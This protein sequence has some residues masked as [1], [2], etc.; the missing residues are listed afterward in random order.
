MSFLKKVVDNLPKDI[1]ELERSLN[2]DK[3]MMFNRGVKEGI[4]RSDKKYEILIKK[5][6]T[7]KANYKSQYESVNP[8]HI[9]KDDLKKPIKV[10]KGYILLISDD[11]NYCVE[12]ADKP[13]NMSKRLKGRKLVMML[14]TKYLDTDI[15]NINTLIFNSKTTINREKIPM[16]ITYLL[17]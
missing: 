14:Y 5:L 9:K 12:S 11:G 3:Q 8:L 16:M 17:N 6:N 7:E 2:N 13:N 10:N 1:K 4:D 15:D